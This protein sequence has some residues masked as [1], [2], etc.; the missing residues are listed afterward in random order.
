MQVK[1]PVGVAQAQTPEVKCEFKP[2]GPPEWVCDLN[3]DAGRL[4]DN[5]SEYV[6]RPA[7]CAREAD[8]SFECWPYQTHHLIPWQ[9]LQKHP[10]T[11]W[12]AKTPPGK[13]IPKKL[14]GDTDYCVDSWENGKF[15][16]YA[17][18]LPEWDG[19]STAEKLRLRRR[20]MQLARMQLHQGP[21]SFSAYA[22]GEAGY[23]TRVA[24]YLNAVTR[25]ANEHYTKDPPCDDCK[26]NERKGKL[27][28]RRNV[29]REIHKV[30]QQLE[31]D[32]NL[33]KIFVSRH[34]AE[35]AAVGGI[36]R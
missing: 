14:Y 29:V 4:G 28:P 35:Y 23:K 13:G 16:P 9:Q 27:A 7:P 17:S 22:A 20:V 3:G 34:A 19:A 18:S 36:M 5:L 33:G 2:P 11:Q 26:N 21:H 31:V 15:M 30:S 24:E 8:L 12:L 10:V 6:P 32:I 25:T 1:L